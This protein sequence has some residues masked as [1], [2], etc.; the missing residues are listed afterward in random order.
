MGLA[1]LIAAVVF[2]SVVVAGECR[3][4]YGDALAKSILFFEGQRSGKLPPNQR[5]KW[6]KDSALEDGHRVGVDL[7]GGYYDAGD[8]VKFGFPMAFSLTM[9]A[10]SMI[11]FGDS[12]GLQGGNARVAIRWGTDYLLKATSVPGVVFVQVGEP[13]FDHNCWERPEDMDTPRDVYAVDRAHPGSEVAAETA[14]ALAA[15]SIVFRSLDPPYASRLLARAA[16]V[17]SFADTYRGFYSDSLKHVVCP[18]YCDYSGYVDD[19]LW[20]AAW[21]YKATE[22][23]QYWKYLVNNVYRLEEINRGG[24]FVGGSFSEFGWDDKHAG[25]FVLVSS[26][27]S[28]SKREA[29][30]SFRR[31][32][33]LLNLEA[34]M[35]Q[36]KPA[37][38]RPSGTD[39]SDFSYRMLVDQRYQK[40]AQEKSRLRGLIIAQFVSLGIGGVWLAFSAFQDQAL[41]ALSIV[42]ILIHSLSLIIGDL[43]RKKSSK[44]LLKLYVVASSVA[45]VLSVACI[46]KSDLPFGAPQDQS[47]PMLK[48]LEVIEAGRVL[49]S[50]FVQIFSVVVTVSLVHNMTPKKAS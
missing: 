46:A 41:N 6:R 33:G 37:P 1:V 48:K 29:A 50:V 14:S 27:C 30:K 39:G 11:E 9:L 10:W 49:L 40:V 44:K 20:A 2:L 22:E 34:D 28:S 15:A 18:F 43:G 8:N 38:G 3:H 24:E 13:Y 17:F 32:R 5:L 42:S 36:R 12:M 19:L 21:L 25:L 31:R 45:S 47:V 4:N 26:K 7:V 16:E 23:D 35:Q